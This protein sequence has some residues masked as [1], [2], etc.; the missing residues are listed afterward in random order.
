MNKVMR[1]TLAAAGICI[2][3]GLGLSLAG[4]VM[5]GEPGF[6]IGRSGL[7]T[8]REVRTKNA[9][10]LVELEKTE[11]D[12]FTSMDVR[13]DYGSIT[14]K[15]SGDDSCY[16]E[17]SLYVRD[18]DPVYTVK[19]GILTFTCIPD[20]NSSETWGSAGFFVVNTADVH[21]SGSLTIYVPENT[22]MNTVKLY[23]SNSD[24]VYAG[25]DAGTLDLTSKYGSIRLNGVK[26]ESAFLTASDG[27]IRCS[28]GT[29]TSL[30]I[31]NKYG[32]TSLE[33]IN[34][35]RLDIEASDSRITMMDLVS[36]NISVVNN[37]GSI[38]SSAVAA[39]SLSVEQSDGT[40]DI[41]M[42]DIKNGTFIN[43][44]G[45][46][47]LELTGTETEYNY[48]LTMKY[49]NIRLNGKSL[50]GEDLREHNGAEKNI[51]MTANDGSMRITTK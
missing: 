23:T 5:G 32:D 10:K 12:P 38:K 9:G 47:K 6:W 21:E 16:L 2:V 48:D 4:F 30:D 33:R 7:Y 17:Y 35:D 43:K 51:I 34:S 27:V 45:D 22:P 11:I 37:Y 24:V 26:A 15:P 41:K 14:V 3:A 40:C 49:G 42:A 20:A 46:I 18:K 28:D 19:N 13:A 50:E 39:D 36:K 31:I 44:Y 1:G 8:N 29:F 25:P